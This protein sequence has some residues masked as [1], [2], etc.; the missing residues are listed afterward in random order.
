MS[1]A[2]PAD[3]RLGRDL[4]QSAEASLLAR[5][6][7]V[8]LLGVVLSF[9]LSWPHLVRI[10]QDGTFFDTD[11]AMRLVQVRDWLAG[12]GWF[13]L[14]EHRLNPPAGLLMHWS[15]V[16]DIAVG[17]LIRGFEPFVSQDRA[18]T[19]ARIV[20]PLA[21]QVA[22]LALTVHLGRLLTGA[23]G[24]LPTMVL[25][26]ASGFMFE[27][28]PAGRIDHHAPQIVLLV[29]MTAALLGSLSPGKAPRAVWA[30]LC[31]A[32]SLAI[33]LENLPF[34]AVLVALL[35]ILWVFDP[36]RARPALLWFA[37]GLALFVPLA[38][39]ATIPPS[40]Y[41]EGVCD[42]FSIAHLTGVLAG[43]AGLAALAL[44][45]GR[46]EKVGQRVALLVLVGAAVVGTVG[47]TFPA[48]L[49]DPYANMDPMLRRLWLSYV[50]EAEPMLK[51]SAERPDTF[52]MLLCPLVAGAVGSLL[53]VLR[54]TGLP[55][56][57][58][59]AI[60][61]LTLVGIAGSMW[62]I[63]V[64][65]STQP[66]ALLG[67]VWV[68]TRAMTWATQRGT[69]LGGLVAVVLALPFATLG[70]AVVPTGPGDPVSA[71]AL[72]AGRTCRVPT[73]FAP[74]SALPTGLVFAPIDDGSHL[75][76]HTP[77]A[78]VAA[79]YHRNQAGN[80]A[81][82]EAF[83]ASPDAAESIVRGSGARY[84][85]LCP[86]ETEITVLSREAPQGL[87]AQLVAGLVPPWL[88]A[89]PLTAT[90]YRV[91]LVR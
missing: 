42:A 37:A 61:A 56:I 15:R 14:T 16:V 67:G 43:A 6:G 12:Q 10:W 40:R 38:F 30:A 66:I 57:R 17:G 52:T 82:I 11:D 18:E 20:F 75:L 5:P 84:V 83:L 7:A 73:G 78:V 47:L 32:T 79:P 63:R 86:G 22:L 45:S 85:A 76:V 13:D 60:L 91:F 90:P 31:L 28:F 68:V 77:H 2:N 41:Q 1:V 25:L 49:H 53:A 27:Q 50:T 72:Q 80:K 87:G 58:W 46:L 70:W 55:R 29:G 88:Q 4:G 23:R 35:P 8:L 19:L 62:E 24:A 44:L 71:A 48:C 89:V 51:A 74:L 26:V 34:I 69:A 64:S 54:E 59:T 39:V 9:A 21:M 65:A 36:A 81:V 3:H 33:S